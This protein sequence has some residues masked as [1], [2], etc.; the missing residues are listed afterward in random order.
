M[1]VGTDVARAQAQSSAE[2]LH[3]FVNPPLFLKGQTQIEVGLSV[4][5][6]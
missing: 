2:R 3:C 4:V 5:G 6:V 1:I